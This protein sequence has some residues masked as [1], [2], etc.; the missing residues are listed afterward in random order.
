MLI[1]GMSTD[2]S[3]LR[4]INLPKDLKEVKAYAFA[5]CGEFTELII[6][7]TIQS[8]TFLGWLN[9]NEDPDNFAFSGCGKLPIK[10]RQALQALGYKGDF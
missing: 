5:S 2:I 3:P 4:K 10:T 8:V 9:D 1:G 6:P 7:D